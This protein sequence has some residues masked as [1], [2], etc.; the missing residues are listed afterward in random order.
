MEIFGSFVYTLPMTGYQVICFIVSFLFMLPEM[1]AA[2]NGCVHCHETITAP[3]MRQFHQD[4]KDS[5]HSRRGITCENCHRGDPGKGTREE[6]HRGVYGSMDPKSSVYYTRIPALCGS[7]HKAEYDEFS[8]S[9][10]YRDF[11]TLGVGPNCVTCHDSMSTKIIRA[12]QIEV[13]CAV[14]HNAKADLLPGVTSHARAVMEQMEA[15]ARKM[16]QAEAVLIRAE[17]AGKDEAR[18]RGFLSLARKEFS[19]CKQDW[20]AFQLNRVATRLQGVE[21]LIQEGL[22]ALGRS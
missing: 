2:E 22:E 14:C 1:A 3:S 6:A 16:R 12:D 10:H 4:W 18:A 9:R 11:V 17:K 13:F 21:H 19:A 5:I 7:C 15:T 20:H 8:T